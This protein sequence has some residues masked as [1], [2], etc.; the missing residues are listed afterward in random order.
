MSFA[1]IS[2]KT[3]GSNQMMQGQ[4]SRGNTQDL[5]S[6]PR[7][8][9]CDL[10][11]SSSLLALIL[12]ALLGPF[13]LAHQALR[14]P[15]ALAALPSHSPAPT[16]TPAWVSPSLARELLQMRPQTYRSAS[17]SPPTGSCIK[18]THCLWR[19]DRAGKPRAS[20]KSLQPRAPQSL[21]TLVPTRPVGYAFVDLSTADEAQK[22]IAELLGKGSEASHIH[23]RY[24]HATIPSLPQAQHSPS[25]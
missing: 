12:D 16:E 24:H 17:G 22:A 10:K 25:S 20:S 23:D 3:A 21:Q 8:V 4:K 14:P 18:I 7:L 2:K 11:N 9:V 6:G 13:H 15:D 5:T 1:F 19:R